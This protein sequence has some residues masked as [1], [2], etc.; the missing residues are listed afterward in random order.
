MGDTDDVANAGDED[1]SAAVGVT[2]EVA[3]TGDED[4]DA[5]GVAS[6]ERPAVAVHAPPVALSE[7]VL[8]TL[9]DGPAEAETEADTKNDGVSEGDGSSVAV[10]RLEGDG[11]GDTANV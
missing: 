1:A 6:I 10:V 4:D 11:D 3:S 2:E 9:S 5:V 8:D 7:G